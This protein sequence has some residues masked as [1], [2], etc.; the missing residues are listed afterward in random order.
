L[1]ELHFHEGELPAGYQPGFEISLYNLS[2]HRLLQAHQGWRCFYA[3]NAKHY[4]VEAALFF[5]VTELG[6]FSPWRAP[7][8]SVEFSD[9]ISPESLFRFLEFSESKLQASGV[10]LISIK[11][12][13]QAYAPAKTSLIETFLF[14]LGYH[15]S[16]AEVGT[17]V[18]VGSGTMMLD[19]WEQ[20]KLRQSREARLEFRS[21]SINDLD[22]IYLFILA[23]RKQ[24]HYTLSMT[25]A[26]LRATVEM[27]SDRFFL[28]G[29]YQDDTLVAASVTVK[30]MNHVLYNF[31]CDHDKQFDSLSPVV[32]LIDG[33]YHYCREHQISLLD[34]GT[35][36]LEGRPNFGLLEFKM[37]MRGEPSA[38]L[39]FQKILS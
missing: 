38:K 29:I 30:V 24:K 26:E 2:E 5:Y 20:R 37:R 34:L 31:Y 17:V 21:L 13:L 39:T 25:L 35:S 6:A 15:V 33:L 19:A 22:E 3:L 14:N 32:F 10:R 23:C 27:F 36:A 8:G 7:F 12:P 11:N 16:T 18:K 4:R 1:E 9:T 28:F